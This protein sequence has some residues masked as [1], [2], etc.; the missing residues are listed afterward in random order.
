MSTMSMQPLMST[1]QNKYMKMILRRCL[2][3]QNMLEAHPTTT[4]A[5]YRSMAAIMLKPTTHDVLGLV[6]EG[7]FLIWVV[8]LPNEP[9]A[10]TV[11]VLPCAAGSTITLT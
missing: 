2:M 4:A 8:M 9:V 3:Q 1:S 11:C 7:R 6:G 5:K 10:V